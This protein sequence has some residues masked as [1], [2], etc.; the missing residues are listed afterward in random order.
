MTAWIPDVLTEIVPPQDGTLSRV[1]HRDDATRLVAFG[2]DA[3]QELTE[4]S[5]ANP[6]IVQV[7]SGRIVVS[8]GAEDH[9]MGPTSWLFMEARTPHS[10]RAE[11]PSVVLL[12][13]I[14]GGG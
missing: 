6:A 12:T 2:F 9:E 3:G 1:L 11:E 4:H 7:V 5:S 13:L 8:V 10:V 14:R